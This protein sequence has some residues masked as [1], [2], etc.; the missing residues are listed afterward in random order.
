MEKPGSLGSRQYRVSELWTGFPI[1]I[2]VEPINGQ[3]M[4][5]EWE[6]SSSPL[7]ELTLGG[8]ADAGVIAF[9]SYL[10]PVE[11]RQGKESPQGIEFQG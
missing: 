10:V 7:E 2:R 6:K 9:C 8:P 5:V 4:N 1:T 3:P 11:P